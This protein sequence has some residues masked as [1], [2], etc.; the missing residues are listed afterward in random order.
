MTSYENMT[1]KEAI[2]DHASVAL[3]LAAYSKNQVLKFRE[4]YDGLL[5]DYKIDLGTTAYQHGFPSEHDYLRSLGIELNDDGDLII[6][7][8][9]TSS[10]TAKFIAGKR[11]EEQ[12]RAEK[13]ERIR[14]HQARQ[15][16]QQYRQSYT[17]VY[18][19]HDDGGAPPVRPAS[20]VF[21]FD[22]DEN[23]LMPGMRVKISTGI[24]YLLPTVN[25]QCK[26]AAKTHQLQIKAGQKYRKKVREI[27]AWDKQYRALIAKSG[28]ANND[29]T[30]TG[31]SISV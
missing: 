7:A 29:G 21:I 14:Q 1:A 24:T 26:D 20:E 5:E 12:K 23:K 27:V 17:P 11:V 31:N 3:K 19:V 15:Q 18:M 22:G 10:N 2:L 28:Y 30:T 13:H 8:T 6:P 9:E 25:I 4:F 16:Q